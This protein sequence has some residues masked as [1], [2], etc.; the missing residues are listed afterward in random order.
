MPN[1]NVR[2][3]LS[4]IREAKPNDPH[5]KIATIDG[6]THSGTIADLQTE[7]VILTMGFNRTGGNPEGTPGR[8]LIPIDMI[9][10]VTTS[11]V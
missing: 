11:V 7:A 3:L 1:Q 6:A 8:I 5:L 9:A 2:A 10:S 4:K